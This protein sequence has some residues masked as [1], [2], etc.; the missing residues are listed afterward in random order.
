VRGFGRTGLKRAPAKS[1]R[2]LLPSFYV[3]GVG[4]AVAP[5]L[6]YPWPYG[7]LM[8]RKIGGRP[9]YRTS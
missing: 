9:Y 1:G 6:S 2:C 7:S 4:V 8:D 3:L 5:R